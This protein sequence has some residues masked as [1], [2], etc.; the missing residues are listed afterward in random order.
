MCEMAKGILIGMLLTIGFFNNPQY[1][2]AENKIS[3][4]IDGKY[5]QSAD[6]RCFIDE[7][8]GRVMVPISLISEEL[9]ME[10][11]YDKSSQIVS[12]NKGKKLILLNIVDKTCIVDGDEVKL[13]VPVRLIN[14]EVYLPLRFISETVDLEIK[15]DS[16]TAIVYIITP[17]GELTYIDEW[18]RNLWN[19]TIKSYLL[20]DLWLEQ[21]IYDAGH[22]L[23][24]PLHAAFLL[25]G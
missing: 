14:N 10:V 21:D 18:D 16:L 1:V 4:N 13:E 5:V 8:F 12:I 24:V 6:G 20:D 7:S 23:M 11:A 22:Y 3:I 15:W 2:M 19:K 9:E 17:D 25:N